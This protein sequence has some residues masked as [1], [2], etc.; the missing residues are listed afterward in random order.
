M[1]A[2]IERLCNIKKFHSLGECT[3]VIDGKII[4]YKGTMLYIRYNPDSKKVQEYTKSTNTANAVLNIPLKDHSFLDSKISGDTFCG[5]YI[6]D[7]PKATVDNIT[8]EI[9]SDLHIVFVETS[10][11]SHIRRSVT[12][13]Q[14]IQKITFAGSHVVYDQ[15]FARK[16]VKA[17][18]DQSWINYL[19]TMYAQRIIN[20]IY[21]TYDLALY[22]VFRAFIPVLIECKYIYNPLTDNGEL[23]F[24]DTEMY[25][26]LAANGRIFDILPEGALKVTIA[27]HL[28]I[29]RAMH[30][31]RMVRFTPQ[32]LY[33]MIVGVGGYTTPR[34]EFPS[35]DNII[36]VTSRSDLVNTG[37]NKWYS[38]LDFT[39]KYTEL[40]NELAKCDPNSDK[41]EKL[42]Q[43]LE[44]IREYTK[45][46]SMM[47][48]AEA[49]RAKFINFGALPIDKRY[50]ALN[51]YDS[52]KQATVK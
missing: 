17:F 33:R 22:G 47:I 34:I 15:E 2:L 7:L 19:N 10:L 21:K 38:E 6:P 13:R 49:D 44:I 39:L 50:T 46:D 18:K 43:K 5:I 29:C 52:L 1:N 32:I 27:S 28:E 23:S 16:L 8:V 35:I 3:L 12:S 25:K 31:S 20:K 37:L 36:Y 45:T 42:E 41:Y 26:E 4:N 14:V 30:M 9:D 24:K 11:Y 48:M 40:K 51:L